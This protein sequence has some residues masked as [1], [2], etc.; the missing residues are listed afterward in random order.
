[1][2]RLWPV[3]RPTKRN[4]REPKR[5]ALVVELKRLELSTF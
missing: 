3:R 2:S 5:P 4:E 1:M